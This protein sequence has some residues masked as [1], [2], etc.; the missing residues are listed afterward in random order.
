MQELIEEWKEINGYKISNYGIIIGKNTGGKPMK[1]CKNKGGYLICHINLG[2]PYG[3]VSSVHRAV[4]MA[5]I[6]NPE[7]KPDVNHIDANKENNRVDNLEWST[8]QE[9]MT[10]SS[11]N[12]LHPWTAVPCTIDSDGNIIEIYLSVNDLS[13][14]TGTAPRHV[15][16][17]IAGNQ[18]GYF[19]LRIREYDLEKG[20]YIRTRFDDSNIKIKSTQRRRIKCIETGEIFKS[21]MEASKKLGISQSLISEYVSGKRKSSV[22]GYTFEQIYGKFN[23]SE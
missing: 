6:P 1:F 17:C 20:D 8:E 16:K 2:E 12:R 23:V 19:G 9:N 14:K 5:F 15:S 13:R 10:H 4:A 11:E 18:D 7:N 22:N 21:Q 3:R